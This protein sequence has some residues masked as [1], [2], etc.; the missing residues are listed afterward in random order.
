MSEYWANFKI[1]NKADNRIRNYGKELK[2]TEQKKAI[3]E[4]KILTKQLNDAERKR[5]SEIRYG[6]YMVIEVIR[7]M[8]L[9]DKSFWFDMQTFKDL[10]PKEK[11]P[12]E[13][14]NK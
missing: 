6:L 11:Y 12:E 8:Q 13:K 9:E 4:A 10:Y 7:K 14:L 2:S 5:G 1:F 3:E